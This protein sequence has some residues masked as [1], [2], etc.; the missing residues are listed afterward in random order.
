MTLKQLSF[1]AMFA[2]SGIAFAGAMGPVCTNGAV[3]LSCDNV[4]W[5]VGV[6]ALYLQPTFGDD[7]RF[8]GLNVDGNTTTHVAN[9]PEWSWGFKLEGAYHFNDG[10]DVNL[11]WYHLDG[12]TTNLS[13]SLVFFNGGAGGSNAITVKPKWDAVNLEFAK[14]INLSATNKI[15]L[16]GGVQYTHIKTNISEIGTAIGEPYSAFPV[17]TFQGIGPRVGADMGYY[18]ASNF[19]IYAKGAT[20]L[21]AGPSHFRN[22]HIRGVRITQAILNKTMVVPEI[23]AKLGVNYTCNLQQS[24]LTLDAGYM[25]VNY[26]GAQQTFYGGDPDND[27]SLQGPY[28]GLKWVGVTI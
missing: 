25:W 4:G 5:D 6:Q 28:L 3:A 23:E 21:L 14:P 20:A 13:S 19:M 15:R 7:L 2:F 16:H 26:F 10:N 17:A 8:I 11:N 9:A 22:T 18:F 12:Q 27:F 1:T 24:L